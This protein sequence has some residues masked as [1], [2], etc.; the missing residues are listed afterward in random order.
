MYPC[1]LP[2][3]PSV[4]NHIGTGNYSGLYGYSRWEVLPSAPLL[5]NP[6]CDFHRNRLLAVCGN[7]SE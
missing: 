5:Q 6:S 2:I 1:R 4:P 3:T 7:I